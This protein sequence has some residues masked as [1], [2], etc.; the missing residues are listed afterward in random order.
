MSELVCVG[1][2]A[3]AFG[4]RGEVRLKSFTAEAED[5]AGYG[6][7]VTEDGARSFDVTV[8][9]AIKNGLSVRLSGV[10]TKEDADALR[11]VRL[12]V[13]RDRFPELDE[14]EYYYADLVGLEVR[15]TGGA[16]LGQVKSVQNHGAADLLEIQTPGSNN[17]ELLPFT[18]ENVPTVDIGAGRVVVDPPEGLF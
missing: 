2:I 10:V 8:G 4:V 15:D 6:A 1:A 3:G 17:T 9:G 13:P 7:L 16:V 12:Y 5:I 11:G 14:D 18:K